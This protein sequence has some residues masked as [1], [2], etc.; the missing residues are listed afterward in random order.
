M[1]WELYI[2]LTSLKDPVE[3]FFK[4]KELNKFSSSFTDVKMPRLYKRFDQYSWSH[5]YK[6]RRLANGS[7]LNEQR[8]ESSDSFDVGEHHD[9]AE[10]EQT[11]RN[12][13]GI[14]PNSDNDDRVIDPLSDNDESI[15]SDQRISCTNSAKNSTTSDTDGD[16]ETEANN[17]VVNNADDENQCMLED[18]DSEDD[19]EM[20]NNED[21]NYQENDDEPLYE[22]Y[23]IRL[24]VAE[25][26]ISILSLSLSLSH[27]WST[28]N[29]TVA[30]Q[31]YIALF[32]TSVLQHYT[33]KKYF[34]YS[35]TPLVRHFYCTGCTACLENGNCICTNC[36]EP[37]EL[38][39]FIEVP[40]IP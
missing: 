5:Q 7:S 22:G 37:S 34:S 27:D 12:F 31:S 9:L 38:G 4:N 13:D 16:S 1:Y 3:C 15:C 33:F 29:R 24:S 40:I 30:N 18:I 28:T 39:Y 23:I 8:V 19:D 21:I 2:Y 11:Q 25:S 6:I 35:N 10:V 20:F 32:I 14:R 36:A 26:L 17:N